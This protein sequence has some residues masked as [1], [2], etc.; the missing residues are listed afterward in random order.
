MEKTIL[1]WTLKMGSEGMDR[2][3]L[4]QVKDKWQVFVYPVMKTVVP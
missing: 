1:K 3:H 2:I 4:A